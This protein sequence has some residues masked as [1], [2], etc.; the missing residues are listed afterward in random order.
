[1]E[2]F[3]HGNVHFINEDFTRSVECYT[4]GVGLI[5]SFA[6]LF[7]NRAAAHIKLRKFANALQDCQLALSIDPNLEPVYYRKGMASYELEEFETAKVAFETGKA[8]VDATRAELLSKYNRAIRKCMVALEEQPAVEVST[9]GNNTAI[10]PSSSVPASGISLQPIRYEY[11]QNSDHMTVSILAKGVLPEDASITILTNRLTVAI[12]RAGRLEI[13]VDKRLY[14]SINVERSRYEIRKTK[15]EIVLSKAEAA[16]WPTLDGFASA[17]L[18]VS[19][20]NTPSSAVSSASIPKPYASGRDWNAVGTSIEK[21]LEADKPEGEEAL[22]KLFRDI[23]LKA[24]EDTRRAMN[25]SFQTSG[26][27][28]LSTNW[29]EVGSKNYEEERQAPKGLE[30]RT[31]E[32]EKLKQV[33]D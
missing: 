11:Y 31:W 23:Y 26:G 22:Q 25:K 33:E 13:V 6:P 5:N 17:E 19:A 15:I 16:I 7:A 32:G 18:P 12:R 1:M 2:C 10:Q 14:G 27:T 3:H 21:E 9:Q 4:E 28:V 8:L 24:D 30:W 29:N 20:A